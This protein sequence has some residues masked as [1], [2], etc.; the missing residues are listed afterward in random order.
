MRRADR[1]FRLL[2]LLRGRRISTG[3]WLAERLEVSLR[4]VYR[5]VRDLALSGVPIE[6]EAGVGYRLG[7]GFE[8]PPLMLTTGQAKALLASVRL[9]RHRLDVALARDAEEAL[10]KLMAVLPAAT[11]TAAEDVAVHALH[12]GAAPALRRLSGALRQACEERRIVRFEYRSLR[13]A[14]SARRVRPLGLLF[15]DAAWTLAAWCEARGDFRNFR[16]DRIEG[17][18][19]LEERFVDEPGRRLADLFARERDRR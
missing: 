18:C 19:V 13:G 17:L 8:L 1:L 11:R 7:A 15:W 14:R 10:A 12:G 9:A 16:I 6:G 4:T 2:E 5:D 3:P